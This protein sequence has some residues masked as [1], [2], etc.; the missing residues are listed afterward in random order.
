MTD[1]PF[2]PIAEI[3][4]N[5]QV[6]ISG[7]DEPMP[8]VAAQEINRLRDENADLRKALRDVLFWAAQVAGD[9]IDM[10]AREIEIASVERAIEVLGKG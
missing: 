9:T 8:W 1:K 7:I 5:T 6:L 4:P 3:K 10:E 2:M